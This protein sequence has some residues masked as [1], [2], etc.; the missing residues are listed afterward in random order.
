[1]AD[2]SSHHQSVDAVMDE[3]P[4]AA[5][6]QQ[7]HPWGASSAPSLPSVDNEDHYVSVTISGDGYISYTTLC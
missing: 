6:M 7:P 4:L 1:M 5:E 3:A 2:A